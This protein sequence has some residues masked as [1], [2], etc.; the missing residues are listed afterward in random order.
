M[1]EPIPKPSRVTID[2]RLLRFS[3]CP[4]SARGARADEVL[5]EIS[6]ALVLLARALER[7]EGAPARVF[8]DLS[9]AAI[10]ASRRWSIS[11]AESVR[12]VADALDG[13]RPEDL[14]A[15]LR[16]QAENVDPTYIRAAVECLRSLRTA[17]NLP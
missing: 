8:G 10:E 4:S 6:R 12:L 1:A 17:R 13:F 15:L 5:G 9:V 11:A 3:T 2:P 16:S 14:L 7:P